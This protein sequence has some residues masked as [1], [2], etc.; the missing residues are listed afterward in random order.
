MPTCWEQRRAIS[1]A[2]KMQRHIIYQVAL[3]L[4]IRFRL[5][6]KVRQS[7]NVGLFIFKPP[8]VTVPVALTRDCKLEPELSNKIQKRSLTRTLTYYRFSDM[9]DTP[10]S[11]KG[12]IM[13]PEYMLSVSLCAICS[14]LLCRMPDLWALNYL[15]VMWFLFAQGAKRCHDLGRSG[16]FQ[17]IPLYVFWMLSG[18]KTSDQPV[19]CEAEK[20]GSFAGVSAR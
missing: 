14:L 20:P 17:F 15:P 16:W 6:R 8:P 1:P 7:P 18:W 19:W 12:R 5:I 3:R 4:S 2:K 13:Q 10:F 11:F 9:F